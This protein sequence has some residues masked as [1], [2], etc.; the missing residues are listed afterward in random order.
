MKSRGHAKTSEDH[1]PGEDYTDDLIRKFIE[2]GC[3]CVAPGFNPYILHYHIASIKY[4]CLVKRYV[5]ILAMFAAD[6]DIVDCMTESGE[7]C[8]LPFTYSGHTF[9]TCTDF[10]AE[11]RWC[12]TKVHKLTLN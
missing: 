3:L 1:E 9:R 10:E 12:S 8:V 6:V 7:H 11:R 5:L 4:V 2:S